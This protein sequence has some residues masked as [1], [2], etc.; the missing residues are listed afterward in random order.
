MSWLNKPIEILEAESYQEEWSVGFAGN[1][2]RRLRSIQTFRYIGCGYAGAR[3]WVDELRE[4][5]PPSPIRTAPRA[6][7]TMR[8]MSGGQYH[9]FLTLTTYGEWSSSPITPPE[10]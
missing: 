9:V 4:K 8:E 7:I 3:A 6:E 2:W 5:Y 1:V 10:T